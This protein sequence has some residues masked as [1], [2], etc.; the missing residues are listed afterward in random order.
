M[1]R[2]A[3]LG[4]FPHH[5]RGSTLLGVSN[6]RQNHSKEVFCR[7]NVSVRDKDSG[8]GNHGWVAGGF[9]GPFLLPRPSRDR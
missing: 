6:P 2:R 3:L 5:Q 7:T 4:V 8:Q 1:S 9:E